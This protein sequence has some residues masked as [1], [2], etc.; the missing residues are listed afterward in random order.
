MLRSS[1]AVIRK[2]AVENFLGLFIQILFIKSPA[3][4]CQDPKGGLDIC[5]LNKTL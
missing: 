5:L 1:E 2:N 3:V 4:K